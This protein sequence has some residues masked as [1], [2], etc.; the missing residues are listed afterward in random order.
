MTPRERAQAI[1]AQCEV[2]TACRIIGDDKECRDM[3]N[4]S[5]WVVGVLE[6]LIEEA[7]IDAQQETAC[8]WHTAENS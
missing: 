7:I 8:A 6:R 1:I 3:T 2:I 4:L 5:S